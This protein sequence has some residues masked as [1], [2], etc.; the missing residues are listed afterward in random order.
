MKGATVDH[1]LSVLVQVD[2][3]GRSVSLV[4]TGCVTEANQHALYPVIR[5][6]RTL[7]PPVTVS[8]DLTAADHVEAIAVDLLRWA[9]DHDEPAPGLSPVR[10][11][12]PV[13]LPEHPSVPA[14]ITDS[15]K[16]AR[17]LPA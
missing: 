14:R 9:T 7:V 12:A 10:I 16:S 1:K 13:Q 5:R 4:I 2:V 17:S 8:I 15:R 11:L 3:D 6:A